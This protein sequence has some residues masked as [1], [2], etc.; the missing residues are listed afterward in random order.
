VFHEEGFKAV[1]KDVPKSWK[2]ALRSPI[3]GPA[4][5]SEFEEVHSK[6]LVNV[7][8]ET[9]DELIKNGADVITLFPV[10]EE[11][12]R[13]GLTVRKVR[14]VGDGRTHYSAGKT[15]AATPSREELLIMVHAIG[16][17][18]WE[19]VHIDEKRAFLN[20]P[21]QDEAPILAKLRGVGEFYRVFGALYGLKTS[22]L[23]HQVLAAERLKTQGFKRL[24]MCSCVYI[25]REGE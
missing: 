15:Y 2:E 13:D 18:D 25:K 6:V 16:H 21:R 12:I 24:G 4:S 9:A 8:R 23:D 17:N 22:T 14:L 11:K 3:W 5:R 20:A 7:D 1:T 19:W 10:Y